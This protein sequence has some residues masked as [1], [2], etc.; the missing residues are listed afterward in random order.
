MKK[1]RYAILSAG[2]AAAMTV[3]S[4]M[5]Y[6]NPTLSPDE[7]AADLCSRLTL[8]EKV[9]LMMNTSPAIERLGIPA[10]EWW[11]EALHGI[12]RN[13]LSTVFPSCIG[14]A[15]SFDDDMI[16]KV[17]ESVSDEARAKNTEARR[18]GELAKYRGISFWTPTVNIFRD[19]RWGRGQESYGEDPY[20]NGRMG[21]RV[22]RALQGPDD[23]RYRKLLAC[24]K[25]FA[26]HS[27]PEKIRHSQ[28]IVDIEPRDLWETYLPAFETLVKEGN[29]RQVM[30]AYNRVEGEA[31]CGSDRLLHQILRDYWG[32]DGIVVSDCGAI[33]D[34]YREGRHGVSPDGQAAA[35]L[36]V[37][38]GTDVECGGIYNKLPQ[39]VKRGDIKEADIDVSIKRL[40]AERF[41]LGDFDPD[42]LVGWTRIPLDVVSSDEHIALA[43]QMGVEQCVLLKNDGVLPLKRNDKVMV[44]GPNANDSIMMW[45]IYYGQPAHTVTILEGMNA[46]AGRTLPYTAGCSI[47][48]MTGNASVMDIFTSSDGSKGLKATYWN[49]TDMSGAPVAE[50]V[51]SAPIHK[52]TGGN[53]AFETGVDLTNFTLSMKGSF[54]ADRDETLT[55]VHNNDDG[56]RIIVNGDTVF[57]RWRQDRLNFRNLPLKVKKG[58]RYDIQ[59]DYMQLDGEGTFNFDLT[60]AHN[61]SI[62]EL[63]QAAKDVDIV[64][65]AGGISPT[66][67]REEAKVSEP[68]FDNGDRTSIELPQCQRD[69]IAA[70]A[71][72]GKKVVLVNCSGSAVGLTPESNHCNAILQAWYAGQQGGHAIADILYGNENPSG[73]LPLTFYTG[74][75]Q[76]GDFEDYSMQ[77]RTYR[78]LREKPLYPFG[79]GL[80][81]TTFEYGT[82]TYAGSKV[83]VDVK[84]TG[85]RQGTEIVQ[86]YIKRPADKEGPNKTLRG[87]CR[88]D[89]APGETKRVEIDMPRDNFEVWDEKSMEMAV[90]PGEYEIYVGPSSEDSLL[91]KISVNI[92]PNL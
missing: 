44:M 49:N 73:K 55:I 38:S 17:F 74:D 7:R 18:R 21:L 5:P 84:N 68:G 56:M 78:Y 30:C 64:V 59:A 52:D 37:L 23:A 82:P 3:N 90:I 32:Y 36:A 11:S 57:N 65:F 53:T 69:I 60:R 72:A 13:G 50:T 9:A 63:L 12:G 80:S 70:L 46:A 8:E 1:L 22:V 4:Q 87:Y 77:G 51:Y 6:Q 86:L 2:I 45:G 62:E 75:S 47:T 61:T 79:H 27:G 92:A 54:V 33:S 35:A 43:R 39:A 20:M 28:N 41:S 67:E 24:A 48:S 40:L 16:S 66:Y 14:M 88:V 71:G 83:S 91:K 58:N 76:L 19:P 15:A 34:F 42:S 89:L 85:A 26:V 81:Y 31:C 25:H 10:F 29:V